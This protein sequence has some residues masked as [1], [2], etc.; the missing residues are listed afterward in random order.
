MDAPPRVERI[1]EMALDRGVTACERPTA[2]RVA[3]TYVL[4]LDGDPGRAVCK[5]GGPS[6][7]TGDVIEPLVMERVG[8]TTD[9]PVPAVLATGTVRTGDSPPERWALYEF[10]AGEQPTP[11]PSLSP[12]VRR[13]VV[14][15]VGSVLGRLHDLDEFDRVGGLARDGDHLR[16]CDPAGLHVPAK[17]RWLVCRLADEPAFQ[18]VL[19]HGDLFPD[20]LLVDERGHITALLD[21]GN[22]H[23]TTAG[24]ALA[25]AELRFIDWFGLVA[26]RT[27][28]RRERQRLRA[29]LRAGYREHRSLPPE[30]RRH[31]R[32]DKLLWLG[33]SVD[34][35]LRNLASQRGRRQLRQHARSTL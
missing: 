31:A 2:G 29:A 6:I 26:P 19:S 10:R 27:V 12:G 21:W 18:P 23:V 35:H 22:A 20:N 9:L 3:E 28:T 14:S 11:F 17:G 33:Q 15:E 7:R 4:E 1:V 30:Y 13:R 34:R 5:I 8:A 25:R 16:V 32:F 24:Y